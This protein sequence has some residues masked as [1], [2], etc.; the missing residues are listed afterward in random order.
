MVD[1]HSWLIL[2]PFQKKIGFHFF[3]FVYAE[4]CIK[5]KYFHFLRNGN[6]MSSQ[7]FLTIFKAE[8]W[9]KK[10]ENDKIKLLYFVG[11]SFMYNFL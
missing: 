11:T 10:V 1:A 7:F 4:S 3:G 9:A 6:V 8:I 5:I 2:P